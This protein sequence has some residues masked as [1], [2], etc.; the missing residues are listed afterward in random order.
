VEFIN[1][2]S[3]KLKWKRHQRHIPHGKR[4]N[5]VPIDK[6]PKEINERTTPFHYEGDTIHGRQGTH[7]HLFTLC[8]RFSRKGFAIKIDGNTPAS[9][10]KAIQNLQL[11][12][13]LDYAINIKT[14]TLDNG[15]EF[16]NWL[17]M[18]KDIKTGACTIDIFFCHPYSSFEKGSVEHFNWMIRQWYPKG[19][20]F[21]KIKQDEINKVVEEINNYPREIWG[22]KT[23]NEIY[24]Q[25]VQN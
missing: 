9:I 3:L 16:T 22:Y 4:I 17:E 8:E 15:S 24:N 23:A 13:I 5:G 12:K 11:N 2:N 1:R 18:S 7:S 6:R 14:L 10:V 20:D 19:T 21:T 25:H